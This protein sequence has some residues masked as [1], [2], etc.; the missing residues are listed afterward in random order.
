MEK[1]LLIL[2]QSKYHVAVFKPHNIS[3]VGGRGVVRPTLLDLVR[4]KFGKDIFPVHRL[5]RATCGITIFAKGS[6]AK[7]AL[8]NA[9]K[10]RLVKKTYYAL[11]EG[12]VNFK[13]TVVEINLKK[14]ALHNSKGPMA[15]QSIKQE[16]EW[17]KTEIECIKKVSDNIFLVKAK[18]I[19]G[20][21]HQI[22]VHLAHLGFPIIGD[23]LYGARTKL[24][25]HVIAL[26]AV[27]IE[28]PLPKG[29]KVVI[30]ASKYFDVDY[31]LSLIPSATNP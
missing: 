11:V 1:K 19:T 21:L 20:R 23:T 15:M 30:D 6:F 14:E 29:Q 31:Y 8:E 13:K 22:R 10:R 16:G 9:F 12:E 28:F 25:K 27:H 7:L 4:D 3:V 24:V 2:D 17:S 18:P 26:G 5:D